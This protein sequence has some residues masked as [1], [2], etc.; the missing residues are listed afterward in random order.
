MVLLPLLLLR[1]PCVSAPKQIQSTSISIRRQKS[2]AAT[3]YFLK[4]DRQK[5]HLLGGTH[6]F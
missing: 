6:E 5:W 2:T 4:K 3:V 1:R